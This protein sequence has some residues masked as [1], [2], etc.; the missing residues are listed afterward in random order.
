M[1]CRPDVLDVEALRSLCLDEDDAVRE[2]I[3]D[4]FE[5]IPGTVEELRA[6]VAVRDTAQTAMI[7]H[8]LAASF[9]FVCANTAM[10][11]TRELLT[12]AREGDLPALEGSLALL[13]DSVRDVERELRVLRG[14]L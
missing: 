2:A 3:D 14:A 12:R 7:A 13:L 4:Y 11:L 6:A 10:T 8:R 1:E 9:G 5:F